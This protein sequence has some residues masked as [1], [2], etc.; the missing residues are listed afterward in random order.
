MTRAFDVT[1]VTPEILL[2]MRSWAKECVWGDADEDS[3]DEM[4]DTAVLRG[5][6]RNYEGG[7]AAFVLA[8]S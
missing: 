4:S 6:Q 7:I 2:E 1:G 8:C 5:I 3:I